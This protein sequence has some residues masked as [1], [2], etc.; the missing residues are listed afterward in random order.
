MIIYIKSI[1]TNTCVYTKGA[2]NTKSIDDQ[3]DFST[4]LFFN[5]GSPYYYPQKSFQSVAR[6]FEAQTGKKEMLVL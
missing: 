1:K 3:Y 2:L 4:V 6:I 5:H